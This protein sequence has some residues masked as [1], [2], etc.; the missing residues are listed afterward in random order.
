MNL[1]LKYGQKI[2]LAFAVAGDFLFCALASINASNK[3]KLAKTGK[4][5][6][7]LILIQN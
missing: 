4:F 3:I 7:S 6:V 2:S 1:S 5:F